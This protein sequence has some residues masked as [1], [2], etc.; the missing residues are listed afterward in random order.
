MRHWRRALR[1]V[2]GSWFALPRAFPRATRTAIEAAIAHSEV[3]HLGEICFAVES[4]LPL[5]EVLRGLTSRRRAVQLFAG[6]GVWETE[7]NTGVL[8]YV[9]LAEHAV[10]I[11]VDRGVAR[12]V[13]SE[14]WEA[15]CVAMGERFAQGDFR[16]GALE[17]V[18]AAAQLLKLHFPSVGRVNRNELPD[19]PVL[20]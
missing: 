2:F 17:G 1:H 16:A 13:S 19:E 18:A 6:L 4:R 20:L 14:H 15:I 8:I 9:L 11:F 5:G 10:E 12:R 7:A 3:T